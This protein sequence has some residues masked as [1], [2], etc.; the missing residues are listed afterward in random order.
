MTNFEIWF[1]LWLGFCI[2]VTCWAFVVV[3]HVVLKY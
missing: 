2:L 3:V 1:K